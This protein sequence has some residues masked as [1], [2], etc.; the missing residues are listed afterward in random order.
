ME[1]GA[2]S[3]RGV[4]HD[5]AGTTQPTQEPTSSYLPRYNGGTESG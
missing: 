4:A 2:W 3:P 5:D 1:H